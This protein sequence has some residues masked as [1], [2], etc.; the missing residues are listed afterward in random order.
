M[1]ADVIFTE[2]VPKQAIAGSLN[3][4]AKKEKKSRRLL[5]CNAA[6][7]EKEELCGENDPRMVSVCRRCSVGVSG[8]F[9][10]CAGSRR[11]EAGAGKRRSAGLP[12]RG[13]AVGFLAAAD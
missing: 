7:A 6:E 10:L 13:S 8:I 3:F 12:G 2:Y 9:D 5:F 1:L 4:E 11:N